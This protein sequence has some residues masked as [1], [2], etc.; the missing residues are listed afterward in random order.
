V[1]L[2]QFNFSPNKLSLLPPVDA[3][4]FSKERLLP[5]G[6]LSPTP[7][8]AR[9]IGARQSR[10]RGV[11]LTDCGWEKLLKMKVLQNRYGEWYS[12]DLLGNTTHLSPRTVSKIVGRETGV[13]RRT[14]KQFFDAFDL[15]MA[16]DDYCLASCGTK[17]SSNP[18]YDS[19]ALVF[20]IRL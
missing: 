3:P 18:G 16:S 14:L 2:Q 9:Q 15:S 13:D 5:D 11:V 4:R 10:Q 20:Y 6:R 12:Y 7:T 8:V 1:S 17:R 19:V